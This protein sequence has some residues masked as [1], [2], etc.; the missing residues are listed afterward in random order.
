M[1]YVR[2]CFFWKSKVASN[3]NNVVFWGMSDCFKPKA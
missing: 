1:K 2:M 3:E